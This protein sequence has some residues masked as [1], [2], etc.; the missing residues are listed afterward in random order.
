M[1]C[2]DITQPTVAL[3]IIRSPEDNPRQKL[4]NCIYT[5]FYVNFLNW[6]MN[7]YRSY[8][9]KGQ[10]L[11][12]AKDAFQ[13][14]LMVFYQKS[15]QKDFIIRTSLKTTIFS[16]ALLQL[17]ALFKKEKNKYGSNIYLEQFDLFFEDETL[18]IEKHAL[19][20]EQESELMAAL[21]Q[22]PKKQR[23]ILILKFFG[24]LKSKE[25]AKTLN[26]SVGNVDNDSTKAYKALRSILKHKFSFQSQ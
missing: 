19:L 15:Q 22:L 8:K 17:L 13:N 26:V 14:G 12:D 23:D 3:E 25:I 20:A 21:L 11:E 7:R 18:E 4:F 24:K 16:F 2:H 9:H 5:L 1:E 10:L 6:I